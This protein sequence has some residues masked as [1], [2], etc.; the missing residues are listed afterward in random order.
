M[1]KDAVT[2]GVSYVN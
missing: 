2:E 1:T